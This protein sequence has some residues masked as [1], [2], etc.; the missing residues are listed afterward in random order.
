MPNSIVKRSIFDSVIFAYLSTLAVIAV[1][2]PSES[3][4]L[5]L[6]RNTVLVLALAVLGAF[7]SFLLNKKGIRTLGETI[8]EP[9]HR[10]AERIDS[11][12]YTSFSGWQLFISFWVTV[13]VAGRATQFD[14]YE[15][16]D[17]DGLEGAVN[18]LKGI[19]VPNFSLL[20]K[21]ILAI[22][23]T[24]FIAFLATVIA[25]PVA[26]GLSFFSAKNMMSGSPWSM[27]VYSVLRGIMNV[28]RSVEPLIWAIIFSI[29]VG[30]GP[31]AGMLALMIHSVASLT[32]Q[33]SE[34]GANRIQV[35][36]FAVVPQIILPYV[37][38]TIYRWDINVRMATIIGMVGGGGIGTMLMQYQWRSMWPEV[39][40]IIVVIAIVVWLMDTASAYLREAIR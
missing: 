30:I 9:S 17:S 8:F 25:V 4:Y 10:K 23:E 37:S 13:Y 33:Y 31:F 15:L 34:T 12:W 19:M 18:L 6:S 35:V 40:A 27:T 20:P 5:D 39:G 3:D 21:A 28:T 22:I 29:W 32:K 16:T 24:I 11:R 26:F 36:W 38:F 1:T 14:I 7:L 2:S